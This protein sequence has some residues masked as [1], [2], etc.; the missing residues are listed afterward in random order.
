MSILDTYY[1]G[2]KDY[3]KITQEDKTCEKDRRIFKKSGL[4][5]DKLT[6]TKYLCTISD[7]WI[8]TIEKGL[9]F[10]EKAVKEERQFITVNGE[11]VPIEKAKKVSK[12]TVAHLARHSNMIT[13]KP[14]PGKDLIPDKLYMVEKLSDFAVYEN[15]FLYMLL[16]YLRDFVALRIEKIQKLRS[17]YT[18]HLKLKKDLDTKKRRLNFDTEFIEERFDNPYPIPDPDTEALLQRILDIQQILQ[19]LLNT[20]LMVEVAKAPMLKPPITKT[21][22]LKMNNN[23]K[24]ALAL[25]NYVVDYKGDGFSSEEVIKDFVPLSDATADE[26][27]EIP[28]LTSFLSYKLGNEIEEKLETQYQLDE[29]KKRQDE[30]LKLVEQIK[31]LKRR[32]SESGL[33]IEEYMVLLEKRNREL[34]ADSLKLLEYKNEILELN[35]KIDELNLEKKELN[36]RIDELSKEIEELLKEIARLN[37]KYIDDM[38]ALKAAHAEEIRVLKEEHQNEINDLNAEHQKEIDDLERRHEE[39]VEYIKSVHE[40]ELQALIQDHEEQILANKEELALER[41]KLINDYE[42]KIEMINAD[43]ERKSIAHNNE[44]QSYSEK[45]SVLNNNI[46]ELNLKREQTVNSYESKL[47]DMKNTY[48]SDYN[49]LVNETNEIKT[50]LQ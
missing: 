44:I 7:D 37:Q 39:N 43:I 32:V 24:N 20:N 40:Q 49:S 47:N 23:F 13:R 2:F 46:I 48:S 9:E 50:E 6:V 45:I 26:L 12:D 36:R 18:C 5:F 35:N 8:I 22:V 34:E 3:R 16:C 30:A 15:R 1:R 17:T 33:D 11:I 31:R 41:T 27:A 28:A 14:E 19:M 29:D 42:N 10:V 25:Y 4:E 21:N 38:N